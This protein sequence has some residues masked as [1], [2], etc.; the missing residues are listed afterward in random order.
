MLPAKTGHA[1][2]ESGRKKCICAKALL[3][4]EINNFI[5][6]VTEGNALHHN[7]PPAKYRNSPARKSRKKKNAAIL[8]FVADGPLVIG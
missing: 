4:R 3:L 2:L 6:T 8:A 1:C 5:S 7:F